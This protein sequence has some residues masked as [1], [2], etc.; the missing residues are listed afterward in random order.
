MSVQDGT[1]SVDEASSLISQANEARVASEEPPI[2]KPTEGRAIESPRGDVEELG[3][4]TLDL[5]RTRRKGFPEVVYCEGKTPFQSARI[6]ERLALRENGNILGT[7]A[8]SSVMDELLP[9]VSDAQFDELSRTIVVRRGE[10]KS[11]GNV[12][13]VAAGTSDLPVAEEAAIT[14]EVMGNHVER[15]YDVGVAGLHRLLRQLPKIRAARVV[16]AV[17]GMEGAIVSVLAGL[18]DMPVIAVP[19]SVGYGAQLQGL[20]PLLGMLTSCAPG[21]AVVNID[22][23][24]GAGYMASLINQMGAMEN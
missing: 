9:R 3:F 6:I 5:D 23:G 13:V 8:T 20:A 22:N 4:A 16:I 18:V 14:A 19:T 10:Q 17:A 15:I 21:V 1:L 24:F 2:D 12:T 11:L 7:R